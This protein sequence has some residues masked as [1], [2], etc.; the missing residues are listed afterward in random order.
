MRQ[1]I[2]SCRI[3][4]SLLGHAIKTFRAFSRETYMD[5]I[6]Q[7]IYFSV[8][9]IFTNIHVMNEVLKTCSHVCFSKN[10]FNPVS[11]K[12]SSENQKFFVLIILVI[13]S[14]IGLTSLLSLS[15]K[16]AV[17]VIELI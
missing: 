7:I 2:E 13:R 17:L 9:N 4:S 1:Q 16:I 6:N 14:F 5:Y 11:F 12:Y 10:K 15:R 8:S 3:Y